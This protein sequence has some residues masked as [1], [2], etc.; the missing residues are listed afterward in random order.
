MLKANIETAENGYVVHIYNE[1][2]TASKNSCRTFIAV[3]PQELS[4]IITKNIKLKGGK[5]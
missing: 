5:K 3:T 4:D 1:S 2:D